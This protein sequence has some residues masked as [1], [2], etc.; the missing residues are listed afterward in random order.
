MLRPMSPRP[1]SGMTR[2]AL[3]GSV[4]GVLVADT[5]ATLTTPRLRPTPP[6][7]RTSAIGNPRGGP[8][9][10]SA[11]GAPGSALAS[12]EQAPAW[13]R[14]S[15]REPA[16]GSDGAQQSLHARSMC[17]PGQDVRKSVVAC[18]GV[19]VTTDFAIILTD[20]DRSRTL[21]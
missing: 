20:P 5:A 17:E 9:R 21:N 13:A 16:A 2:R 8:R 11:S 18:S 19:Q 3:P 4:G 6:V 12:D 15:A 14:G 7:S 1:P 10:A